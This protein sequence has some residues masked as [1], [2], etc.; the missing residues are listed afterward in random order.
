MVTF[1][2]KFSKYVW[3]F[4]IK[5]KCETLS[6]FKE[7]KKK[8]ETELNRK[9]WLFLTDNGRKYVSQEFNTYL[10]EQ[11]IKRQLTCPNTPQGV[12]ERKNWHIV[13]CVK[14]V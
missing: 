7:F 8:M 5:E 1:I 2:D 9:V 14:N 13:E 6:N 4:F 10:K 3:V 11:R 12:A